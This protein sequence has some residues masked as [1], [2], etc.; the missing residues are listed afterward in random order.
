M[1]RTTVTSS[2]IASVGYDPATQTLE[3]EFK[4]NKKSK[5]RIYHYLNVPEWV[6]QDLIEPN[7]PLYNGSK[8]TYF[9]EVVKGQYKYMEAKEVKK[10]EPEQRFCNECG[11]RWNDTGE[12]EC[13]FCG[14]GGTGID[15]REGSD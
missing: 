14:S 15:D 11:E 12:F 8:G 10:M 1:N 3:V 6:F 9:S 2:N 4:G 7:L 13:P 5:P